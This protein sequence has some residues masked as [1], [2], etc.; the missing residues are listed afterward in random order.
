MLQR[1]GV[2]TRIH[3]RLNQSRRVFAA[4][5][6]EIDQL[7][8]PSHDGD[9]ITVCASGLRK[10]IESS[11]VT[12]FHSR[13]LGIQPLLKFGRIIQVEPVEKWTC[14]QLDRPL[15]ITASQRTREFVDITADE[16]RVQEERVS[17]REYGSVEGRPDRI[18]QLLEGVT[19]ARLRDVRPEESKKLVP[20]SSPLSRGGDDSEQSEAPPVMPVLAKDRFF[21][22]AEQPECAQGQ[23]AESRSRVLVVRSWR[24][25]GPLESRVRTDERKSDETLIGP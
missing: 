8:P 1:R 19:S 4:D 17:P 15:P 25:R 18:Y 20:A 3:Q 7:L 21:G 6:I 23:Q 10:L 2:I 16:R 12:R 13:T 5:G 9:G 24:H 14:V 22:G 11:G